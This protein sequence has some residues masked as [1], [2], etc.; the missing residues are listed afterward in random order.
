MELRADGESGSF[1]DPHTSGTD[2]YVTACDASISSSSSS[3]GSD[4]QTGR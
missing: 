2:R 3:S 4:L 1:R